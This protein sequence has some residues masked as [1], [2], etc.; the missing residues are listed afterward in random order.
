M[1]DFKNHHQPVDIQERHKQ[2]GKMVIYA[3][4]EPL[5]HILYG[6]GSY[7][8]FP[9]NLY[10]LS[11]DEIKRFTDA[12]QKGDWD[13]AVEA[14]VKLSIMGQRLSLDQLH[15]ILE[16]FTK[17]FPNSSNPV[18]SYDTAP[19]L[20]IME[21]IWKNAVKYGDLALLNNA[22]L[23]LSRLYEYLGYFEK[24]RAVITHLLDS[25]RQAGDGIGEASALNNLGYTFMSE[26][27][28]HEALP[29]FE[30][31]SSLYLENKSSFNYANS[32]ANY[33]HC[34]FELGD[35]GD[36]MEAR[37]AIQ[38]ISDGL[39]A[40]GKWYERKPLI[41][42]ARLEERGCNYRKA[43]S[44]AIKAIRS[45]RFSATK[46]PEYDRAY[47]EKLREQHRMKIHLEPQT[48]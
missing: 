37:A 16:S 17:I 26:G 1:G 36:E 10:L 20:P 4:D 31:A 11:V 24:S 38:L 35:W 45:A 13:A 30:Q 5:E 9:V 14:G 29:L 7:S 15:S 3:D 18:L 12:C 48:S 41:L 32:M 28:H 47:L 6:V 34:R 23:L 33:W 25:C 19:G 22:G 46:F 27:R 39:H 8:P 40:S 21:S 44:L 42:L 2:T 43:A